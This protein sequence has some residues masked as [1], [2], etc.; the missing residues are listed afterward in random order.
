MLTKADFNKGLSDML[1]FVVPEEE[2]EE[3]LRNA[4][5]VDEERTQ[6]SNPR[7]VGRTRAVFGGVFRC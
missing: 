1:P 4:K 7:P 2:L 6:D 5:K 3:A